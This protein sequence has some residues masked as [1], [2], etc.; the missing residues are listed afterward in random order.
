MAD[1]ES[2]VGR[3]PRLRRNSDCSGSNPY[4]EN[5]SWTEKRQVL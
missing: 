5:R 4:I 3:N 2:C 1:Q